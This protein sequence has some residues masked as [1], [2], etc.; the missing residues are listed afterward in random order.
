MARLIMEEQKDFAVMPA[1]SILLLK[2]D[3]IDIRDVEGDR[4]TWQ[5][6]NVKFKILDVQVVGDGS[7]KENYE[8]VFGGHIYGSVPFRLTDS[9]ENKLRQWLEAIFGMELTLGFELDTDL[10]L[11]KTVRGITS[12]YTTKKL[13]PTTQ[14]GYLRH[15]VNSLLPY[16]TSS[17]GQNVAPPAPAPAAMDPWNPGP[18]APQQWGQSGGSTF[19]DEP[20]F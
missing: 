12:T 2:V 6:M 13:D 4:G 19:T 3:E 1:D 10:L 15:Q 16:G 7:P 17:L 5:K 18:A 11:G 8:S 14:K 9:P 20:P